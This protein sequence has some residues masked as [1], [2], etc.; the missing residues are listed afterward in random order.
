GDRRTRRLGV[1]Q[2]DEGGAAVV[3]R[4]GRGD[5]GQRPARAVVNA[6]LGVQV[7]RRGRQGAGPGDG[8]GGGGEGRLGAGAERGVDCDVRGRELD[9]ARGGG[10]AADSQGAGRGQV[11]GS[12]ES[13]G[14]VR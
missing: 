3:R 9:G 6:G 14:Q 8:A 13:S 7:E 11:Q 12:H 5:D 2:A 10:R 4:N 1:G